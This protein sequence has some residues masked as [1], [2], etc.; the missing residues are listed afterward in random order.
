MKI[1]ALVGGISK[2]SLNMKL[3]ELMKDRYSEKMDIEIL[4]IEELPYYSQDIEENPPAIVEELRGKIRNADGILFVTP[5]Y[6]YSIPGV[7]K[8]AID[9]FS[10][11]EFVMQ[12]KPGL[13]VGA[14]MGMFGTARAQNHLRDILLSPNVGVKAM[15][16][17]EVLIAGVHN[18]VDENGYINNE[19]TLEFLDI[20]VNNFIDWVN[21]IK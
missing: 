3:A 14:A 20:A 19:K 18:Q 15:T 10:R 12:G 4:K 17:N 16:T 5:E 11:V 2:N 6:N 7:L 8:N 13:I 9:W 21:L 1:V